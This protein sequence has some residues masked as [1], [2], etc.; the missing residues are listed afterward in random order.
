MD[1][2]VVRPSESVQAPRGD[3]GQAEGA[4]VQGL[5]GTRALALTNVICEVGSAHPGFSLYCY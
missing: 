3:A 1:V 4:L 5:F 2:G